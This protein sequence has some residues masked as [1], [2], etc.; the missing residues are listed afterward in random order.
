MRR[1]GPRRRAARFRVPSSELIGAR[2][3]PRELE[4]QG[5]S[6]RRLVECRCG[7]HCGVVTSSPK[8]NY[9]PISSGPRLAMA[10]RKW[11]RP[12]AA[13]ARHPDFVRARIAKK[14]HHEKTPDDH[15]KVFACAAVLS[16]STKPQKTTFLKK[17][18][19][20]LITETVC[21][22]LSAGR[23]R[24][25]EAYQLSTRRRSQTPQSHPKPRG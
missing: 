22:Y 2:N 6:A 16:A 19:C 18:G 21:P 10:C 12:M 9:K 1:N 7:S 20:P 5:A 14:N 15:P 17:I 4:F 25:T 8:Y 13:S 3:G 23:S 24:I 11:E